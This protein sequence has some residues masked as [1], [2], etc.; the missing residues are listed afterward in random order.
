MCGWRVLVC[1]WVSSAAA[2][3][4]GAAS[5]PARPLAPPVTDRCVCGSMGVSVCGWV[6]VVCLSLCVCVV[7]VWVGVFKCVGGVF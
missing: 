7:W 6:G 4:G 5:A 2:E 1:G 3:R